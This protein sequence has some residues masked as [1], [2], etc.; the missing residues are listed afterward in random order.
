MRFSN[1]ACT[2]A[3]PEKEEHIVAYAPYLSTYDQAQRKKDPSGLDNLAKRKKNPSTNIGTYLQYNAWLHIYVPTALRRPSS[4]TP[5]IKS[6]DH[7]HPPRGT[8]MYVTVNNYYHT[9][10][11][12]PH[13]YATLSV[14]TDSRYL[15]GKSR[16]L[17]A[18][19][20][21]S[22]CCCVIHILHSIHTNMVYE[23]YFVSPEK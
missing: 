21:G 16:T 7:R 18:E 8:Y 12:N 20:P 5:L 19:K 9:S 11:K 1:Y 22:H 2:E 3:T 6:V 17:H 13:T 10:T 4:S 23:Y 15:E 14:Q